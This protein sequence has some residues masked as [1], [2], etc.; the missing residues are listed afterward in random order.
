[1]HRPPTYYMKYDYDLALPNKHFK[2][3]VNVRHML[4]FHQVR[5]WMSET[6]GFSEN[7][8][9]DGQM[10]NTHWAFFLKFNL[11]KIYLQGDEEL[12]WFKI[13][14]GDPE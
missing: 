9:E 6:Y 2:Y 11:H 3:I 7:I 1:M 4:D 5:Q 12:S 14:W 8:E 13:K 10:T